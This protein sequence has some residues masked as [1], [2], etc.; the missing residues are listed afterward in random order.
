M[1]TLRQPVAYGYNHTHIGHHMTPNA[2][3][4]VSKDK[5]LREV[6]QHLVDN[7]RRLCRIWVK[8]EDESVRCVYWWERDVLDK[9]LAL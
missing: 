3:R 4:K 1:S 5:P 7:E 2:W 9:E 6:L 8:Y